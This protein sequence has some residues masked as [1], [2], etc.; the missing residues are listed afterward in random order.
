[1][2]FEPAA[3]SARMELALRIARE[4]GEITVQHFRRGVRVEWKSDASPVTVADRESESHL[5]AEIARAFPDDAI[6]GEEYGEQPGRSGYRWILD[7]I[8]GTKSFIHGVPLYGT[9]IG[10]VGGDESLGGV[11]HIPALRET[12]WGSR[13]EP[14]WHQVG[15]EPP[16]PARVS[17]TA[18]L[19]DALVLTSE[20][21]GYGKSQRWDVLQRLGEAARI[22]R[23]WGDAYGYLMVAVGRGDV[24]IDPRMHIW[25]AAA[26]Q[27]V[28]EAAGGA[29]TDWNGQPRVD[30]GNGLGGN[31]ALLNEVLK[32]V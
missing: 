30:G 8:D 16:Q 21:E 25:D 19:A 31:R 7:P 1:M 6:L 18:K 3:V 22:T 24:M 14:A 11:I 9:L 5:R 32:L 29:F 4:A 15:S 10:I 17:S 20:I 28:L 12:A 27:P 13:G 2:N 23:T 26:V